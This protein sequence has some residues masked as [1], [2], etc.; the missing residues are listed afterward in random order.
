MILAVIFGIP[1]LISPRL[2]AR[3]EA[4]EVL[5]IDPDYVFI[6]NSM[7]ESRIDV[8]RFQELADGPKVI[9]LVDS[10]LGASA[11]YLRLKNHVIAPGA[12]PETV[13]IFSR[14]SALTDPPTDVRGDQLDNLEGLLG[15]A[16]PEYDAIVSTNSDLNDKTAR[17]IDRIYPIQ[18]RRSTFTDALQRA[19][20]SILAGC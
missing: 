10:G 14:D 15:E 13:F 17:L 16:E 1:A 4:G 20:A 19:S 12:K 8:E 3:P 6:G 2:D 7:L 18:Q 11:W 5:A 9:S